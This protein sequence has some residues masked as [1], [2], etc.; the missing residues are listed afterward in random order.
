MVSAKE[1]I[2]Y[3]QAEQD[4]QEMFW[5]KKKKKKKMKMLIWRYCTFEDKPV[6]LFLRT[7]RFMPRKGEQK[8][9]P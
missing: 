3:L 5:K 7:K 9:P 4:V 2:H 1:K 6:L 8:T